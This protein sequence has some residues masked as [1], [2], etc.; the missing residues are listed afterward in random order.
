MPKH[1][2]LAVST[3]GEEE[4][5]AIRNILSQDQFTM[6]EHV[7]TFETEFANYIGSNFSIMV[8]SGSSANLLAIAALFYKK[9]G[10]LKRG[11]E[12]IVPAVSWGTTYF[13][14]QQY[15]LKVKFIDVNP[16][17]L[18]IDLDVLN[19]AITKKTKLIIAVNLLGN[20]NHLDVLNDICQKNNIILVEDNCESMGATVNKKYAGTY[21][22][23]GTFSTFFSHHIS[24]IEGGLVVTNDEELYHIMLSMRSHGW[25]R[26]LPEEN[27]VTT[28]NDRKFKESFRFILPGYN[29]RPSEINAVLGIEQLKKLPVF[30]K[31]RRKN[32]EYFQSLFK[33]KEYIR[34]QKETGCSSWFGFSLILTDDLSSYRNEL[35]D[36][37]EESDIE[38]RPIV[39][40]NFVNN[41]VIKFFD[42]EIFGD[43][44]VAR[45]I[46]ECGLYIGNHHY[47]LK[48]EINYFHDRIDTF[49]NKYTAL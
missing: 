22:K 15:G 34:I 17:T 39:A 24:T 33:N 16:E 44:E 26:S 18:N 27:K 48:D 2:P 1:Y 28:K 6:G 31:N 43:L 19:A 21:G 8:N 38:C 47:D 49:I 5:D 41:D 37:L 25:T 4:L 10:S 3:W 23:L 35:A 20:P 12:V 13:P 29:I 45:E 14:L 40:G 36:Y 30:L 7:K 9:T 46:D 11:D 32:A 42:Y